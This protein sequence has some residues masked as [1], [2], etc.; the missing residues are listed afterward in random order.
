MEHNAVMRPLRQLEAAGVMFDRVPAIR[1]G[2]CGFRREEALV[3]ENTRLFVCLHASNRLRDAAAGQRDRRVLSSP[4]APLLSG[5][6]TDCGRFSDRYAGVSHRRCGV[7][8]AQGAARSAGD[9]GIVL[10]EDLAQEL[11][12]LLAGGTGSMS[13]TEFMPE[14]L[15]DRFEPGTMN[16]PGLRGFT[17]RWAF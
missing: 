2:R 8:G 4:S 12:P 16:L 5:Q 17:L 3:R 1:T 14:F 15:P 9:G 11:T 13:H 7:Y 6:R 10:R